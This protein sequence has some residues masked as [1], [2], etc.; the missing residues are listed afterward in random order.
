MKNK[1]VYSIFRTFLL[2]ASESFSLLLQKGL[3]FCYFLHVV[4]SMSKDDQLSVFAFKYHNLDMFTFQ[5]VCSHSVPIPQKKQSK[6]QERIY[7][8]NKHAKTN[9]TTNNSQHLTNWLL[10]GR[11]LFHDL[12]HFRLKI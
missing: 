4:P 7:T 3:K 8:N 11:F 9:S 12:R 5:T 1:S 6:C 2:S 10:I